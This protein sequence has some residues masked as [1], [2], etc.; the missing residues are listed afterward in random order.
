M[1]RFFFLWG[2]IHWYLYQTIFI[3]IFMD[4]NQLHSTSHPLGWFLSERERCEQGYGETR[5]LTLSGNVKW[6][7]PYGSHNGSSSK[8]KNWIT[9][10]SSNCISEYVP[11]RIDGRVLKGCLYIPVC[12]SIIHS[13]QPVEATQVSLSGWVGKRNAIMHIGW[14]FI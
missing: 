13:S 9:I 11:K 8:I 14:N 12:S 2:G 1:F 10:W 3:C 7:G 6:Y 5:P 4:K